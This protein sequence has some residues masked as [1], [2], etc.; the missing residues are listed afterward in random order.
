MLPDLRSVT[1]P[2]IVTSFTSIDY[3]ITQLPSLGAREGADIRVVL[4]HEPHATKRTDFRGDV[5][6]FSQ[7]VVDYWLN[8]GISIM[9]S[10][11]ALIVIAMIRA[12]KVR[13]RISPSMHSKIYATENA[14]TVGSSNFSAAGQRTQREFNARFPSSGED[15]RFQQASDAAENH[16]ILAFD[17]TSGILTL[18]ERLLK[19]V[20]WEEALARAVADLRE[21]AWMRSYLRTYVPD[22]NRKLWPSQ[23]SGV[24]QALWML[25]RVGSI[26][27]ADAT[28]SGKTR[29][30]AR[31]LRATMNF[32]ATS[33]RLRHFIPTLISPPRDV[34]DAWRQETG[35]AGLQIASYSHG[36]LSHKGSHNH[37]RLAQLLRQIQVLAI[38]EAHNFLNSRSRRT[39]Q[40]AGNLAEHV[41]LFTATPINRSPRDVL[42]IVDL[43]GADNFEPEALAAFQHL[44]RVKS[45]HHELSKAERESLRRAIRQ[46]TLRRTKSELNQLIDLEPHNYT[47][48]RGRK[49]RYPQNNPR[50]YLCHGDK[51]D[52]DAARQII[53]IC[54]QLSG[55]IY[56][57]RPIEFPVHL[58]GRCTEDW[59]L[60]QRLMA[61]R[62]LARHNI[63]A[64]MRSSRAALLEHVYGS[65]FAYRQFEMDVSSRSFKREPTGNMIHQLNEADKPDFRLS[66]SSEAPT[67]L[68]EPEAYEQERTQ[69]I[70][71]YRRIGE[72]ASA[73]LGE[74]REQIKA[75]LIAELFQRHPRL[76]AF[77]RHP[78][79][80]LRL[81]TII[82]PALR[83]HTIVATGG[84]P[85]ERNRLIA[86]LRPGSSV[87]A[88]IGLCSDNMSEGVNLQSASAVI[89]LDM[90]SVPR[91]AEQRVGRIE[92]MNSP[93][94]EIESWWPKD[95]EIF[96]LRQ[97]ELLP[98]RL[99]WSRELFGGTDLLL[100]GLEL[101]EEKA[102]SENALV[103]RQK[104]F[105]AF[106]EDPNDIFGDAFEPIHALVTGKT[107]LVPD[108]IYQR[109]VR[110]QATIRTSVS[111][112]RSEKPWAFI[113]LHN[114]RRSGG[115][116]ALPIPMWTFFTDPTAP[117]ITD[118]S[119]ICTHL[120]ERLSV[121]LP[122]VKF[123]ESSDALV[124]RFM[125]S[126]SAH[127]REL[128][129]R[130]KQRAITQ[131]GEVLNYYTL[132]ENLEAPGLRAL[133]GEL[134]RLLQPP[135][136]A[137]PDSEVI[138]LHTLADV[139]LQIIQP[140]WIDAMQAVSRSRPLL[141]QDLTS[142]LCEHPLPLES[143]LEVR[144]S[145]AWIP[146][147]DRRI[148]AAIVGVP[149]SSYD[150]PLLNS[151]PVS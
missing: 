117:P 96:A 90:P 40:L 151:P 126:L 24:A 50:E 121:G 114:L 84:R 83:S 110:S 41:I 140:R 95:G 34:E 81:E 113:A 57:Q 13:F 88:C 54:S 99:R 146:P 143:I 104:L 76:L 58:R 145:V 74:S 72:V 32:L 115:R 105:D 133:S 66:C 80:L 28:G 36:V 102:G 109:I 82:N 92:R 120:R 149:R 71:R 94:S 70:E 116:T 52:N 19:D 9:L 60:R 1:N 68:L 86:A 78:I 48:D 64:A 27:V 147:I 124:R 15:G 128:L 2:L 89:M 51:N 22:D 25:E 17:Y 62:G 6:A 63:L 132:R 3:L 136:T 123:D 31:L 119:K 148:V 150:L 46:F 14:V 134:L 39:R 122:S 107:A 42:K 93:H 137:V 20:T 97:D 127:E 108:E 53:E 87:E 142:N 4:G 100:P 12:G 141:L 77:D 35:D 26:L 30:G 43:L 49:C 85:V 10:C 8:R 103:D 69:E 73:I 65:E 106:A 67:W 79:T 111:L 135:A 125:A 131:M 38:D 118:L 18:L 56:L 37:G 91:L 112:L 45:V 98:A 16:W 61:A 75:S 5:S 130:K 21:G 23:S 47:D 29:M 101:R 44:S 59:Y 7:E 144:N 33:G 11:D 55:L 138:D 139:W 129:P